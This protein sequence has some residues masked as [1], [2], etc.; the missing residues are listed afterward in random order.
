MDGMDRLT[1]MRQSEAPLSSVLQV[2]RSSTTLFPWAMI[3]RNQ[4]DNPLLH[5][6]VPFVCIRG[7]NAKMEAIA[8]M[9]TR[10]KNRQIVCRLREEALTDASI[11]TVSSALR[12]ARVFAYIL[13]NLP[14]FHLAGDLLAGDFGWRD[15]DA[16][17]LDQRFPAEAANPS[18]SSAAMTAESR[19]QQL[20]HCFGGYSPAHTCLDYAS[21]LRR[22]VAGLIDQAAEYGNDH[23]QAMTIVLKALAGFAERHAIILDASGASELAAT[24]R[25]VPWHPARDFREALQCL[26]LAHLLVGV[27]EYSDSS[28]SL[29]RFDQYAYP[30]YRQSLEAGCREEE[31]EVL[32]AALVDK[33]NRYGDAACAINL[34]GLSADG[35]DLCNDLTRM[36]VRVVK[37]EK[38]PAPIL[39]ARI[40]PQFPQDLFDELT[41][42]DLFA[43]GQP[44]FYGEHSCRSAL[45]ERGVPESALAD[46]AANS[47]MGLVVE[48]CEVSNMWGA[49]VTFL[50]PLELAINRGQ[51]FCGELPIRLSTPPV[52]AFASFAELKKQFLAYLA[53]IAEYCLQ[54]CLRQ[55]AKN[56]LERPNPYVSALLRNCAERGRDRLDGGA[57][58]HIAIVEAFGLVNAADAL[59]AIDR[60]VFEQRRF[61][62]AEMVTAAKDNFRHHGEILAAI[63]ALRKFGNGDEQAD[64]MVA[65][66]ADKFQRMVRH[67]STDGILFAPSFHTLNAHVGAGRKFA[68]SL[69]GRFA[70][71][72]LAKNIGTSPGNAIEGVTALVRSAAAI[73]QKD[74]FGGQAL[75]ISMPANLLRDIAAKR[76]T[77]ALIQTYFALGGLQI[78]INGITAD[79]LAQALQRPEEHRE[80]IVRIGGYSEYFNNLS[81]DI[82]QEMV[83]RMRDG[84]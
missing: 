15:A 66:L 32:F 23:H 77:Q 25:R 48:G 16:G 47:C 73:D 5:S 41:D 8:C 82:R 75:D 3:R 71:A 51:P 76:Q 79:T 40:H 33:L 4:V 24:C 63:R 42:H 70:G 81:M 53:E 14:I 64:A 49:V 60:L 22:G 56:R 68:A 35:R 30:Y 46:W 7:A 27:S 44:T 29:G 13:D 19:L 11:A 1:G 20:F 45:R 28:L 18:A 80:L 59:L 26:W 38:R 12:E 9:N 67:R 43:M 54:A 58:Y 36:I 74:Y 61:T 83:T 72:P 84:L 10:D 2:T 62:L 57:A 31:L 34:G 52:T 17:A 6:I 39:A 78:Q 21:L 55:T 65:M 69:D 37:R 50:L